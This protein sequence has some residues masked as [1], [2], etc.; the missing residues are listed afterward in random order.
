MTKDIHAV[1][2]APPPT[3]DDLFDLDF[4]S[5]PPAAEP[6]A[7]PKDDKSARPLALEPLE[8]AVPAESAPAAPLSLE[9]IAL[10]PLQPPADTPPAPEADDNSLDFCTSLTNEALTVSSLS[11][12][13]IEAPASPTPAVVAPDLLTE[14]ALLAAEGH[15]IESGETVAKAIV[16]GMP[17]DREEFAWRMLFELDVRLNNRPIF[18]QRALDFAAVFEKSPPVWTGDTPQVPNGKVSGKGAAMISLSGP[19]RQRAAP[20]IAQMLEVAKKR[21]TIHLDLSRLRD[22]DEEGCT[23]LLDGL[24]TLKKM[25]RECHIEGAEHTISLAQTKLALGR[26][27]NQNIWLLILEL[28]QRCGENERF[29]DW[30][31]NYAVTFEVSPPAYEAPAVPSTSAAVSAKRN[32]TDGWPLSGDWLGEDEQAF[33]PLQQAIDKGE[34][35]SAIDACA[36]RCIDLTTAQALSLVLAKLAARGHRLAVRNVGYLHQPLLE[37]AQVGQHAHIELHK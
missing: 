33:A 14:A 11:L 12:E 30:A 10:E 20:A 6:E 24:R 13:P 28:L 36:L 9:P 17:R 27:E 5:S 29:D 3:D 35:I 23:L 32:A 19:L 18:E 15:Y 1:A 8:R 34:A 25:R 22:V 4:T 31:V 7:T 37:L 16:A 2:S 26:A 21:P